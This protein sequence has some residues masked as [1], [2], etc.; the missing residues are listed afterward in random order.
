MVKLAAPTLQKLATIPFRKA[1]ENLVSFHR[2]LRRK[3]NLISDIAKR[4]DFTFICS[5]SLA[6]K[7]YGQL[8]DSSDENY[9]ERYLKQNIPGMNFLIF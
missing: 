7:V 1:H 8:K 9:S 2:L 6:I 3:R 4:N 5:T